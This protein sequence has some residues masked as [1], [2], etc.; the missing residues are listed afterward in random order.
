MVFWLPASTS[1]IWLSNYLFLLFLVRRQGR[2]ILIGRGSR[3]NY[4]MSARQWPGP[5]VFFAFWAVF[6]LGVLMLLMNL[7]VFNQNFK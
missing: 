3:T 4:A 2:I 7:D 6:S 5:I 1:L